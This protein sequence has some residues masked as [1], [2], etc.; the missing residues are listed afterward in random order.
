MYFQLEFCDKVSAEKLLCMPTSGT[1]PAN[2]IWR[3]PD[4]WEGGPRVHKPTHA[5]RFLYKNSVLS[6][7][8][9]HVTKVWG[10]GNYPPCH[11]VATCLAINR[12]MECNRCTMFM[13]TRSDYLRVS[14][15][16]FVTVCLS[17]CKCALYTVIVAFCRTLIMLDLRTVYNYTCNLHAMQMQKHYSFITV[18]KAHR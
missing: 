8:Y 1:Q 12:T 16:V 18:C 7:N 11:P 3:Q 5:N 2:N 17:S 4:F 10:G 14:S 13:L 9:Y 6:F 15:L